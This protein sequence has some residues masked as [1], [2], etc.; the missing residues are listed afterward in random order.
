MYNTPTRHSR[1]V[2]NYHEAQN[3]WST[4]I[5]GNETVHELLIK[6]VVL[7]FDVLWIPI[8]FIFYN[9]DYM[10][11]FAALG[12]IIVISFFTPLAYFTYFQIWSLYLRFVKREFEGP[13]P[14]EFWYPYRKLA[15]TLFRIHGKIMHGKYWKLFT[16]SSS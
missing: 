3:G 6:I 1:I 10:W 11:W 8:D 5:E 13:V 4:R 14:K 7:I 16:A 9:D 12:L 15:S 2:N